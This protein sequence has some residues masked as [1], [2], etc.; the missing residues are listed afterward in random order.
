MASLEFPNALAR[1]VHSQLRY[2]SGFNN[3]IL[4]HWPPFEKCRSWWLA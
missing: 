1:L 3:I 2:P 4:E